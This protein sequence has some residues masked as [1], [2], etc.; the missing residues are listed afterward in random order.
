ML[1]LEF[2]R[3][4]WR[5]GHGFDLEARHD[6]EPLGSLSIPLYTVHSLRYDH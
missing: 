5:L 1:R 4:V 3:Y 2:A 6:P